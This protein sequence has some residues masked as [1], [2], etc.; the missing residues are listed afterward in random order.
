MLLL[1]DRYTI[2]IHS[3][4]SLPVEIVYEV[5]RCPSVRRLA[6]PALLPVAP[7]K[8]LR[9]ETPEAFDL[10]LVPKVFK[11]KPSLSVPL[12]GENGFELDL[13][14]YYDMPGSKPH[15]SFN[16]DMPLRAVQA[17]AVSWQEVKAV[18]MEVVPLFQAS[19]GRVTYHGPNEDAW[20]TYGEPKKYTVTIMLEWLSYYG[21]QA[22]EVLARARFENLRTCREK[23]PLNDGILIVLQ[24]EP[25][26]MTN[27]EHVARKRQAEHEL[28]FDE[29]E[30]D[31]ARVWRQKPIQ[32]PQEDRNHP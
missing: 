31:E 29:L 23:I 7:K 30:K 16:L 5:L 15:H 26:D 18:F 21:P 20:I 17:G 12:V 10:A 1:Q 27:P 11:K 3:F 22:L 9:L 24:E 2:S 32:V 13:D 28:G 25:L 4:V 6:F 19:E 8:E 14:I